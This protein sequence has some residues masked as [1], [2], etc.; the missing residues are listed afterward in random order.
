VLQNSIP[1][2]RLEQSAQNVETATGEGLGP[3][4]LP[5]DENV[6]VPRS[7]G[8]IAPLASPVENRK[9]ETHVGEEI[10]RAIDRG[11]RHTFLAEND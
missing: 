11:R 9:K 8:H 4:A 5:A 10:Y 2:L 3:A 7:S 1:R 6:G